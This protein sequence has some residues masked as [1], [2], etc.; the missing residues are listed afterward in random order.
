[1]KRLIASPQL[2][3]VFR[4]ILGLIFI[5]ASIHKIAD[6]IAFS[7]AIYNYQILPDMLI[8]SLAIWLPWLELFAGLSLIIGIWIKG[9]AL[10]ISV[11]S[12]AFAIAVGSA[13]FR[14]LD[15]S[16]GCF[17][18]Y[19]TEEIIEWTYMVQ[20]LCLLIMGLQVLFFDKGRYAFHYS[21][22]CGI[23]R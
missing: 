23:K 18:S 22:L 1:M 19:D 11:L 9:G 4:W 6:P 14:G 10:I 20:D 5:Y 8:N 16:C 2:A 7:E 13:L 15:I 17:Y 3:A 12:T 21:K